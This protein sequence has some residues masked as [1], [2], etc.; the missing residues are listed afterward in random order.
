[1]TIDDSL[2]SVAGHELIAR[3]ADAFGI[4]EKSAQ[5]AVFSLADELEVRIQRAMLSRG[6]VA[7]V[8]SLVTAPGARGV[9]LNAADLASP[10]LTANG[11]QI[12][13]VLIGNKHVSRKIAARVASSSGL[14]VA[15]VQKLLPVVAT[16]LISEL[17][18]QSAPTIAKVASTLPGFAG[19]GGS[20]LPMPGEP[21]PSGAEKPRGEINA[22]SPLPIPGDD[23]PGLG[24]GRSRY[25]EPEREPEDNPYSRLPDI[26]RRGG[27]RVPPDSGGDSLENVIRSILGNLLGSNSGVVG[28][29]IKLFIVRW[30]ASIVRRV[31]A[32][33]L[34]R[35]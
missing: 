16:L 8:L 15:T 23:I 26:V 25:P 7:D 9:P 5:S 20:P 34:G 22:G 11:D 14:D 19:A 24:R 13:N 29:M 3:V 12:L 27:E 4:D 28:T 33:A 17:Q 10:G 1:M 35:R 21:F 31:L 30:I 6:G 18:R 32:Q 2:R